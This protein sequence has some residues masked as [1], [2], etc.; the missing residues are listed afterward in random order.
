LRANTAIL[1]FLAVEVFPKL[2]HVNLAGALL[3]VLL[4]ALIIPLVLVGVALPAIVSLLLEEFATFPAHT[5]GIVVIIIII[6]RVALAIEVASI[7]VP[8]VLEASARVAAFITVAGGTLVFTCEILMLLVVAAFR[9]V[10]AAGAILTEMAIVL[11]LSVV[12]RAW[13]GLL[14]EHFLL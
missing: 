8:S 10:L 4:L 1:L 5:V 3:W 14:V 9:L 13:V 11:G 6:L 7:A 12:A 2:R